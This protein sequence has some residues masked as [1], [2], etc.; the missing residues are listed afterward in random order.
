MLDFWNVFVGRVV[1][2]MDLG[3]NM[4]LNG[5][6]SIVKTIARVDT[7]IVGINWNQSEGIAWK[8]AKYRLVIWQEGVQPLACHSAMHVNILQLLNRLIQVES[9]VVS[10]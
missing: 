7:P 3:V 10:T 8:K 5:Y 4:I 9:Y 1:Q 6:V 2:P